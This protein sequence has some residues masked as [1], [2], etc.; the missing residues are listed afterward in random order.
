MILLKSSPSSPFTPTSQLSQLQPHIIPSSNALQATYR[1]YDL[2]LS[3]DEM[4]DGGPLDEMVKSEILKA[5]GGGGKGKGAS[6]SVGKVDIVRYS[7]D[8][9]RKVRMEKGGPVWNIIADAEV[10]GKVRER[11]G[12]L[13]RLAS[14]STPPS[15]STPL[16]LFVPPSRQKNVTIIGS[17]PAGVFA[18]LYLSRM[19]H[20]KMTL[21]ER[22][23]PV[24]SRGRGEIG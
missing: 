8:S 3:V 23:Q 17:G 2:T 22:G 4:L 12:K 18:A 14:Q 11:R 5:V 7:F 6:T 19:P 1:F 9:R 13:E 20:L 24:E 16:S 15:I 21:L 10:E